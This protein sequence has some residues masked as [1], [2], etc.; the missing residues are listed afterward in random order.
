[1]YI[2]VWFLFDFCLIFVWFLFDCCW[3][4][5][6]LLLKLKKTIILFLVFTPRFCFL[7]CL[8][9]VSGFWFL[10]CLEKRGYCRNKSWAWLAL[11]RPL[12]SARCRLRVFLWVV[13]FKQFYC[14]NFNGSN[15]RPSKDY[16][17]TRHLD[18]AVCHSAPIS[19]FY[20]VLQGPKNWEFWANL[21]ASGEK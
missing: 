20:P 15:N 18:W 5:L 16:G 13:Y 8:F 7:P 21:C 17:H 14:H 10:P 19:A 2:I 12:G 1:M 4:S 6:F 11:K 9:L 3:L